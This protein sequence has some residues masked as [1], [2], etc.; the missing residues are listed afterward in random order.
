MNDSQLS[1]ILG[2]IDPARS[3]SDEAIDELS[4]EAR[5]Q[6]SLAGR[7]SAIRKMDLSPADRV[8]STGP[9]RSRRRRALVAGAVSVALIVAIAIGLSPG[10]SPPAAALDVVGRIDGSQLTRLGS[11][12]PPPNLGWSS[13]PWVLGEKPAK[14]WTFKAG[15]GLS[16]RGGMAEAYLLLRLGNAPTATRRLADIFGV[17]GPVIRHQAR[18]GIVFWS[19]GSA[20]GPQ[21]SYA[22]Q[23]SVPLFAYA[24]NTCELNAIDVYNV[25]DEPY[26]GCPAQPQHPQGEEPAQAK[27]ILTHSLIDRLSAGWVRRLGFGYGIAQPAEF[28]PNLPDIYFLPKSTNELYRLCRDRCIYER[29]L[30]DTNFHGSPSGQNVGVTFDQRGRLLAIGGPAFLVGG[31]SSYPLLSASAAV[32]V[33]DQSHPTQG[34]AIGPPPTPFSICHA[35]KC[36]F[37]RCRAK[38]CQVRLLPPW[39]VGHGTLDAASLGTSIYVLRDGSLITLP[40]YSFGRATY[41]TS[42]GGVDPLQ[43]LWSQLA[44]V[45]SEVR[46]SGPASG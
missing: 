1:D 15:P 17:S 31:G 11:P 22:I 36:H 4:P 2:A 21:V 3:L 42:T 14:T 26:P 5:L 8:V 23:G 30:F 39:P 40:T 12:S 16:R 10:S 38:R 37:V 20:A 33:L 6:S 46:Y 45:P 18:G 13:G 24:R 34:F 27:D 19:I 35:N 43:G 7:L 29:A 9:P 44:V 32:A 41:T 28:P 25:V